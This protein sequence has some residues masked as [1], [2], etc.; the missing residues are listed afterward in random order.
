M[1]YLI[2][3]KPHDLTYP[4]RP[5]PSRARAAQMSAGDW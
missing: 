3:V 1:L 2:G 4:R 5:P